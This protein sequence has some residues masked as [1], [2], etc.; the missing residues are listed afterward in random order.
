LRNTGAIA[1]LESLEAQLKEKEGEI[2]LLQ[3]NRFIL[4]KKDF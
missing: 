4:I 2:T 1:V 3:V